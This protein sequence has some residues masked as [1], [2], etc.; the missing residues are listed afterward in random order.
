MQVYFES[1]ILHRDGSV[2]VWLHHPY[3]I[4]YTLLQ[5]LKEAFD[6]STDEKYIRV[7]A[8]YEFR[9]L[10]PLRESKLPLFVEVEPADS[11]ARTRVV[12]AADGIIGEDSFMLSRGEY[13]RIT[14]TARHIADTQQIQLH[15]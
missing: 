8:I 2:F 1:L 5:R 9:G 6:L 11:L 14:Q 7:N 13:Q 10:E 3:R 4:L 12:N 15:T